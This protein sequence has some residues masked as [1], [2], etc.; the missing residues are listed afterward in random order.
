L[1]TAADK[2][3]KCIEIL[4]QS[5]TGLTVAQVASTAKV[6]WPAANRLLDGLVGSSIVFKDPATKR[7]RLGPSLYQ[8][9]NTAIQASSPINIA[10]KEFIRLTMD[11]GRQ[12][13]FLVLQDLEIL[14][15]ERCEM[16]DGV[17][18]NRPMTA[19]RVWYES[20][21]GKTIVA[22]SAP[23]AR[24]AIVD[25]SY[26]QPAAERPLRSDLEKELDDIAS[27][28]HAISYDIRPVG[29]AG[30]VAP[31]V[32]LSGF[33]VA[34]I[35]TFLPAAE[36]DDESGASLVDQLTATASRISHYLG[37]DDRTLAGV[38]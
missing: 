32:G 31:I 20:G 12:V 26:E 19:R 15:V 28:G 5:A 23:A 13:N 27:R 37:V 14:V 8:W 7:Y 18:V 4:A 21:G 2:T 6:S 33:A 34:A 36:L 10:R 22:F 1:P 3:L 35:G 9:A 30:I 24:H 38:S 25:V 16:V 11:T 17:P 29:L